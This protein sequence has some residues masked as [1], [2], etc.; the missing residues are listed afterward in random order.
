MASKSAEARSCSR[1]FL[2][3][4]NAQRLLQ[5]H[6]ASAPPKMPTSFLS[7]IKADKAWPAFSPAAASAGASSGE[8]DTIDAK[9]DSM[10]SATDTRGSPLLS[11]AELPPRPATMSLAAASRASRSAS[12]AAC[13]SARAAAVGGAHRRE[14]ADFFFELFSSNNRTSLLCVCSHESASFFFVGRHIPSIIL[15]RFE[16]QNWT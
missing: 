8:S 9:I 14:F 4:L 1:S 11:V 10:E 12:L 15:N 2:R 5:R 16:V 6:H 7:S 13:R 3:T